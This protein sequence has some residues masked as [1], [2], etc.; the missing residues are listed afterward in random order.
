[1]AMIRASSYSTLQAA[2]AACT[3]GD[4]LY[5]RAGT[6]DESIDVSIADLTIFGDGPGTHLVPTTTADHVVDVSADGLTIRG[7]KITGPAAKAGVNI[8]GN[9]NRTRIENLEIVNGGTSA[10]SAIS[11]TATTDIWVKDCYITDSSGTGTVLDLQKVTRCWVMENYIEGADQLAIEFNAGANCYAGFNVC[12]GGIVAEDM[13]AEAHVVC[14]VVTIASGSNHG[15]KFEAVP[16]GTII[17]NSVTG[18]ANSVDG[19]SIETD[20]S[21]QNLYI[22]CIGN[23]VDQSGATT[24]SGISFPTGVNALDQSI[25]ALNVAI[26]GGNAGDDGIEGDV[27]ADTIFS[28]NVC[29]ASGSGTAENV[30]SGGGGQEESNVTV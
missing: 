28:H 15:I 30:S 10:V 21:D 23:F 3:A 20:N 27:G 19:I 29:V 12:T 26:S 25:V 17:G 5:I 2:L 8:Q 22:R 1:M 11:G 13:I 24:S 4:S 18:T 14:N 7:L 9:V 16:S 6:Y